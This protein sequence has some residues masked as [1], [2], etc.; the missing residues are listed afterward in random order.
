MYNIFIE[1]FTKYV[2]KD[3]QV[4]QQRVNNVRTV[5]IMWLHYCLELPELVRKTTR[6][7]N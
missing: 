5:M 1:M 3:L 4:K 7:V 6:F 2:H